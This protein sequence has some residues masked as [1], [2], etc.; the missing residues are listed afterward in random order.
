VATTAHNLRALSV[1]LKRVS[2][3]T[4]T[5]VAWLTLPM[6][7]GTFVIVV[8]RYAL[9][10]GWI[11]MQEGVVW[12][13]AAVFMLA[14]AYTLNR[15]EHVRVDIFY[16]RMSLRG[17]AIVNVL[18]VCL[19]LLPMSIFIFAISWDY[20]SVSWQIRE[21]SREAGGLPYPFVPVLKS[22]IVV[23]AI[24]LVLQAVSDLIANALIVMSR[25]AGADAK[26][27]SSGL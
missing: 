1:A 14:A 20:V 3:F 24:L 17:Q 7:L 18:G 12:L 22:I 15:D 2:E 26:R 21:G 6:V 10:V 16:R 4:G 5:L 11:W 25:A 27:T 8:L 9:D 23:T 13:H 19:F